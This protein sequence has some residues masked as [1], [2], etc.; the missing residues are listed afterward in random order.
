MITPMLTQL[1]Y[2]GLI[3]EF[4]GI[5]NC[6]WLPLSFMNVPTNNLEGHVEL[7]ASLINPPNPQGTSPNPQ[8]SS[9]PSS[10]GITKEPKKKYHLNVSTD[11]LFG[12]L[13]D[14]NF[15]SV[16]KTLNKHARRL[17]EDY[18]VSVL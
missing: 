2:E 7:P 10:S 15:A 14:L 11:T 6:K 5:K 4:L 12:E 8:G 13:R 9:L 16:G 18:K 1:T 3:D 17:D